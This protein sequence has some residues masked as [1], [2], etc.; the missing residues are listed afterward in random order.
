MHGKISE[1]YHNQEDIFLKLPN[2]FRAARYHSLIINNNNLPKTLKV[3][4]T[5]KEGIIMGCQHAEH[6]YIRGIQFH[7][8]SLWTDSGKIIIKNFLLT[9]I[10]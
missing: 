9:K 10:R 5:T 6:P 8:E 4:A 1:I 3:T 7:P 2:P